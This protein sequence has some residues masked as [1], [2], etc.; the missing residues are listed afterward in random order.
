MWFSILNLPISKNAMIVEGSLWLTSTCPA[1]KIRHSDSRACSRQ[2][3]RSAGASGPFVEAGT[4]RVDSPPDLAAKVLSFVSRVARGFFP[5]TEIF[6][7]CTGGLYSTSN[8]LLG[9]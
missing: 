1:F 7:F 6:A 2:E 8:S 3:Q 9:L 4:L 5:C